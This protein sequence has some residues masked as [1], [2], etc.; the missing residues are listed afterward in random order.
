LY[1]AWTRREAKTKALGIP[2]MDA[3]GGDVRV[4]DVEAP[5]GFAASVALVG[6]DPLVRHVDLVI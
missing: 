1:H 6:C 3:P 2:L 4:I 5:P